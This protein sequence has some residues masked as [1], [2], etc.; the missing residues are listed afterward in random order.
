M[1]LNRYKEGVRNLDDLHQIAVGVA[2]RDDHPARRKAVQI[3][4]VELITVG[5]AAPRSHWFHTLFH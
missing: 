4:V 1:E 2:A 5:G 3:G